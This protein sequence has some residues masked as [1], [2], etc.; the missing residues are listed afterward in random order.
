M[1]GREL[2]GKMDD[3][4]TQAFANKEKKTVIFAAACNEGGRRPV[5]YPANHHLVF[6]IHALTGYGKPAEFSPYGDPFKPNF[7]I[8]GTD[9]L[10]TW[11]TKLQ[12]PNIVDLHA[13]TGPRV[14]NIDGVTCMT[15]YMSGTSFAAPL[16]AALVANVFAYYIEHRTQIVPK[17]DRSNAH[18]YRVQTFD[19]VRKVLLRMSSRRKEGYDIMPWSQEND[20]FS[21]YPRPPEVLDLNVAFR[22]AIQI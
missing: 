9:I 11:P 6:T 16:A 18:L 19:G 4:I 3:L 21:M 22:R 8:L 20:F 17:W 10:S 2:R 14:R 7:S 12:D 1:H 5:P 13:K 15:R